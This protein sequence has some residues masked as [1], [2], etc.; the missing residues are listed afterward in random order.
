GEPLLQGIA[1]HDDV[2]AAERLLERGRAA[3]GAGESEHGMRAAPPR[4]GDE[5]GDIPDFRS[6]ARRRDEVPLEREL[7]AIARHPLEEGTKERAVLG[8]IRGC[9]G[10][11]ARVPSLS[12][13]AANTLGR[14]SRQRLA[15]GLVEAGGER[16]AAKAA[17][18]VGA[19]T[20]PTGMEENRLVLLRGLSQCVN[21]PVSARELPGC[22]E[23]RR[24]CDRK[25]TQAR[26][27]PPFPTVTM[28]VSTSMKPE[29]QT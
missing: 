22:A 2:V 26:A 18:D 19:R 8:R 15:E 11:M 21:S 4:M 14:G 23:A 17:P 24:R 7:S 10:R 3:E 13:S 29:K 5:A 16:I 27:A 6:D 12:R 20:A 28:L 1:A 9:E 25:F